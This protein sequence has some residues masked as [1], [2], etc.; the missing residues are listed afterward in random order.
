MSKVIL[1]EE[2]LEN[3]DGMWYGVAV[4]VHGTQDVQVALGA[5]VARYGE[6]RV[7]GGSSNIVDQFRW[8][9]AE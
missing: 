9:F 4:Q 5:L 7:Y 8:D 3:E 2:Q 6:E 1:V